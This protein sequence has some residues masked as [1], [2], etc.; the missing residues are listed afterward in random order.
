VGSCSKPL[1]RFP[2]FSSA[3]LRPAQPAL[4]FR[5]IARYLFTAPIE[6]MN[7]RRLIARA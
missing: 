5:N 4:I 6:G 7:M 3:I 1:R 2:A